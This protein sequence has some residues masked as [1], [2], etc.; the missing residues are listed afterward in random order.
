MNLKDAQR[1]RLPFSA[2]PEVWRIERTRKALSKDQTVIE[3]ERPWMAR[4]EE[5]QEKTNA[6]GDFAA[7]MTVAKAVQASRTPKSCRSLYNLVREV[8]PSTVLEIGT[9]LGISGAYICAAMDGHLVT[10]EGS[11]PKVEIARQTLADYNATVICGDFA[12]TLEPALQK[13]GPID[14]AFIDGFHDGPAT[15]EYY[16]ICKRYSNPG[17]VLIFD[18]ID[19]SGGM[20]N[21]WESIRGTDYLEFPNLGILRV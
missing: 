9:N 12:D 7:K 18:D 21:A 8:K 14:L 2:L 3:F 15:I 17:A 1:R 20:R 6:T 5:L 13:H 16:Q 4:S 19:W 10:L 11:P